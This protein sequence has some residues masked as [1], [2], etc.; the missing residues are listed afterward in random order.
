[1]FLNQIFGSDIHKEKFFLLVQDSFRQK[2][3]GETKHGTMGSRDE[4]KRRGADG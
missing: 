3:L 2:R 1:M 4:R